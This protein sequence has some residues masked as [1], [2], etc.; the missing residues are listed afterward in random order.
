M[1]EN[2][3]EDENCSI[4]SAYCSCGRLISKAARV[5]VVDWLKW[6]SR[7]SVADA[8]VRQ[9]MFN[10][11]QPEKKWYREMIYKALQYYKVAH[12]VNLITAFCTLWPL[13]LQLYWALAVVRNILM[14]QNCIWKGH[15]VRLYDEIHRHPLEFTKSETA[16]CT[17]RIKPLPLQA[18]SKTSEGQ[19]GGKTSSHCDTQWLCQ[20]AWKELVNASSAPFIK[21]VKV[22]KEA[23]IKAMDTSV[24]A[25]IRAGAQARGSTPQGHSCLLLQTGKDPEIFI[26]I[27]CLRNKTTKL[28]GLINNHR[29]PSLIKNQHWFIE[30][31]G[32]WHSQCGWWCLRQSPHH[33]IECTVDLCSLCGTGMGL[34]YECLPLVCLPLLPVR[35]LEAMGKAGT[36]WKQKLH[37]GADQNP[38]ISVERA[39]T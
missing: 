13:L 33:L 5:K 18:D 39:H 31:Q 26:Q 36:A 32:Y 11:Q 4:N 24:L 6:K 27:F 7:H 14:K 38:E 20:S 2:C 30:V 37:L 21:P 34:E 19:R 35:D 22:R 1:F 23:N 16:I 9:N 8:G 3:C 10:Q 17:L 29:N 15:C 12:K 28:T 25:L